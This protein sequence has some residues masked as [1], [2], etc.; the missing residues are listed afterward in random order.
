MVNSPKRRAKTD[1][2]PGAPKKPRTVPMAVDESGGGDAP[3]VDPVQVARNKAFLEKVLP[4]NDHVVEGTEFDPNTMW[5]SPRYKSK[6]G[7]Y[8]CDVYAKAPPPAKPGKRPWG[9][10]MTLRLRGRLHGSWGVETKTDDTGV[11]KTRVKIE[12]DKVTYEN[13]R[14]TQQK[15]IREQ[16]ANKWWKKDHASVP[17]V[18]MDARVQPWCHLVKEKEKPI[19]D[20]KGEKIP[21]PEEAGKFLMESHDPKQYWAPLM[22][23]TVKFERLKPENVKDQDGN[24]IPLDETL[25]GCAAIL[26]LEIDYQYFMGADKTGLCSHL[27][28]LR[29]NLEDRIE[30]GFSKEED[31]GGLC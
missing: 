10:K 9:T 6:T 20:D 1:E 5:W 3:E 15:M 26:M 2:N 11:P 21:D 31:A 23:T 28:G 14:K 18:L 8:R 24:V 16:S 4:T 27:T 22:A 13:L 29:V 19:L 12:V 17:Q 7:R 30:A 25:N